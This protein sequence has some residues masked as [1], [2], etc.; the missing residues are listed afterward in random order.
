MENRIVI[1]GMGAVTPV[2]NNVEEVW[3]S[4][5]QGRSGI[6]KITKFDVTDYPVTIAGE[7]KNFN[8]EEYIDKK[9]VRKMDLFT[10]YGVAASVQ[11]VRDSG[12]NFDN[13][14]RERVGV[15]VGSGIGGMIT[16]EEQHSTL[17]N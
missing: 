5:I 3:N 1:T 12:L 2:G 6:S 7:V 11:A 4:L 9:S 15:I 8:P 13:E 16:F 17:L 10:Q 14:N